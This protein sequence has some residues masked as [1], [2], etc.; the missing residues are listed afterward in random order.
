M[1]NDGDGILERMVKFD[2]AMVISLFIVH[3][4]PHAKQKVSLALTGSLNDACMCVA[5]IALVF[6]L[7]LKR[8]CPNVFGYAPSC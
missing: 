8:L 1:D 2:R 6:H 5:H 4:S 3:M 7:S